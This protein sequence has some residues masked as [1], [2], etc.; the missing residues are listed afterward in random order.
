MVDTPSP[1]VILPVREKMGKKRTAKATS[2]EPKSANH[3]TAK[4]LL[5][6]IISAILVAATPVALAFVWDVVWYVWGKSMLDH[7]SPLLIIV[8]FVL[9][10]GGLAGYIVWSAMGTI[11]KPRIERW[12]KKLKI[13]PTLNSPQRIKCAVSCV[14]A[15]IL[16][17]FSPLYAKQI[18]TSYKPIEPNITI[19]TGQ[20]PII[21]YGNTSGFGIT[22][23][24]EL[25][26]AYQNYYNLHGFPNDN[27]YNCDIIIDLELTNGFLF[28][29]IKDTP[30]NYVRIES[31]YIYQNKMR[32]FL[33]NIAPSFTTE[34]LK[35]WVGNNGDPDVADDLLSTSVIIKDKKI[36]RSSGG[37]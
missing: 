7:L 20:N 36:T 11:P 19:S 3:A 35:L 17:S 13:I 8:L 21:N 9:I 16:I 22:V 29:P 33:S 24:A 5:P 25:P 34:S 37:D 28:L 10:I 2:K 27:D 23:Q 14:V 4:G 26:F 31:G 32:I 6:V 18:Y 1:S 30:P 12:A 15:I